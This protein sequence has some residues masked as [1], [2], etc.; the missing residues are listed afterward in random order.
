M[1]KWEYYLEPFDVDSPPPSPPN[2]DMTR[3]PFIG[4]IETKSSTERTAEYHRR[5]NE[6]AGDKIGRSLKVKFVG[7][8]ECPD[9]PEPPPCK[10]P[11]KED[12][13]VDM[14]VTP[15]NYRFL[16]VASYIK[17]ADF[18]V[19]PPPVPR[20]YGYID[21]CDCRDAA[22]SKL[23]CKTKNA[24]EIILD[25]EISRLDENGNRH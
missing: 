23:L 12:D 11:K 10:P 5:L 2:R 22:Y 7:L 13:P 15:V 17:K 18:G 4:M 24:Q 16:V 19:S 8:P 14:S 9:P 25:F 21:K 3:W 6:F 20:L 1:E